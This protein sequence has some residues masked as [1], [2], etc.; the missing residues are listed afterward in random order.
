[1]SSARSF[2]RWSTSLH[3]S[4]R[5]EPS[6]P[7][8][9]FRMISLTFLYA[10]PRRISVSM[11]LWARRWRARGSAA[12]G[13]PSRPTRRARSRM[14]R[15]SPW[16]RA[17]GAEP[18]AHSSQIVAVVRYRE[19]LAPHLLPGQDL[20]KKAVLLR[21]GAVVDERRAHQGRADA[22]VDHAGR[23]EPGVLLGEEELLHRRRAPAPVLARPVEAGPAAFVEAALPPAGEADLVGGLLGLA[24]RGRSPA[25]GQVGNQPV[26]HFLSEVL[27]GAG[28]PEVHRG[29]PA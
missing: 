28:E 4:L 11:K 3:T 6:G 21:L 10:R 20:W 9:P 8:C 7:G 12:A 5:H 26:V 2:M 16:M 13:C 25:R 15:I 14:S 1:M 29:A 22:D 18:L 23:A 24:E 27:L 19:A 17:W